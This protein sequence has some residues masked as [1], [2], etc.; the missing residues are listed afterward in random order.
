MRLLR[1]VD[2]PH[3][4]LLR[5]RLCLILRAAACRSCLSYTYVT[6]VYMRDIRRRRAMI[7]DAARHFIYAAYSARHACRYF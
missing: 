4:R 2:M 6:Y 1:R 7:Y 5:Q 3:T